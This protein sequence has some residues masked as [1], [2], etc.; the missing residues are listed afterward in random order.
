MTLVER[1]VDAITREDLEAFGS[2]YA[3]DAVMFEPML[4]EPSR[5]RAAIV[6]GEASLFR[7]FGQISVE[8]V[9]E[10]V[11]GT[12]VVAEVVLRAVH[13]GP[14]DTGDGDVPPT[15]RRIEVPMAWAFDLGD[16]GLVVRERDYFDTA[17]VLRQLGLSE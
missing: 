17:L 16:D 7:A 9:R 11:S 12:S 1:L 5:G 6:A 10:Y 13:D 15:G 3:E 4:P 14:L 2:V 8:V